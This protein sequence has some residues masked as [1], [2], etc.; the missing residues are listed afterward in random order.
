MNNLEL[1]HKRLEYF[2]GLK[3][4]DRMINDKYRAFLKSLLYSYQG[5]NVELV[6]KYTD[7][8][9]L[10]ETQPQY[11]ALIN[12][13]KLKQDYDDKVLSIDYK[14]NYDLGDIF[15]WV[16]TDTNWI[17]YLRALTEDA[18]FRGE[19][20]LCRHKIK[21]KDEKGNICS[22]WAAIRGP[23]ETQIESIQK[24]QVRV[25]KP[26]L[27]LNILLP[28]NEQTLFAFDRYSEFLFAGKCW[29]VQAPDSISMKNIIE[30]NAEEYY[31]NK[32]TDDKIEEIKNGLVIEP[33]DPSP[34]TI[35]K[36][37]TFI[38][39]NIAEIYEAP[40]VGGKWKVV[41]NY[42]VCLIPID[43]LRVK[44]IWQKTVSGQFTLEW[45]KD[46]IVETK[47]IVVESLF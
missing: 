8:F 13:D 3:Q 40:D 18:Y 17:I 24:G 15:K 23:V 34:D 1:M 36:G 30:V 46:H 20:R 16:G 19:I 33:V 35:I 29:Q 43:D 9:E 39:P 47:T 31:I 28:K 44:V 4:E 14:Y 21:F 26:N 11:R 32:E 25:D 41:E 5:C 12:P 42:P 45:Y 37:E 10:E 38:K 22:T 6:Q 27:S 2:G 7:C